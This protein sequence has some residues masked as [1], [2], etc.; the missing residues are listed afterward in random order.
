VY[1]P[2]VADDCWFEL[3]VALRANNVQVYLNGNL[4]V[5]YVEP[6]SPSAEPVSE[7]GPYSEHGS[8]ALECDTAAGL[9]YRSI[10]VQPLPEDL[11][12]TPAPVID[13]TFRKV[14][15]FTRQNIPMVDFHVHLK[16]G[17]T[18]DQALARSRRDGIF[19]G[20]AING[21]KGFPIESDEGIERF[22][23]SMKGQPT[24][25]AMQAEGREWRSLF[26]R[27]VA[28]LFDYVFTDSMTWSDDNGKRMRLW[29][30]EEVGTITDPQE[31]MELLVRRAVRILQEEPIDIYVNPT[32]LPDCISEDYDRLWTGGRMDKVIHAAA[33]SQIAIEINDR[34]K[35]PS[36]AFVRRA[37]QA[38]CKFTFGTNNSGPHDLRRSE[39][40]LRMVEECGLEWQDFFV[41]QAW[42]PK[43]VDRKGDTLRA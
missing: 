20:I 43:A 17:L 1:K 30:P 4:L 18:L 38:G 10:R 8:V 28:S 25:V 29:I 2:L 3:R 12:G 26:S 35:I 27:R 34:Y 36:A 22:N 5:D 13:D 41:P 21:G 37:K 6:S 23:E 39:Y 15:Q 42:W 40:G 7:T 16:E 33:K 11:P 32:Y 9:S 24:F 31:F 19:Y 14:I